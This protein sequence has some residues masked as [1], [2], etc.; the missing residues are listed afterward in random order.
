ME[1]LPPGEGSLVMGGG[2]GRA[3]VAHCPAGEPGLESG[4]LESHGGV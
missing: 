2:Q 4:T 3:V 1:V